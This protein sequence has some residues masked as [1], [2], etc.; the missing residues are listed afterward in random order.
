MKVKGFEIVFEFDE[1]PL[2]FNEKNVKA[3]VHLRVVCGRFGVSKELGIRLIKESRALIEDMS[4]FLCVC[5]NFDDN[6][7]LFGTIISM[8]HEIIEQAYNFFRFI[9]QVAIAQGNGL[10]I[11]LAKFMNDFAQDHGGVEVV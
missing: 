10:S 11:F 5:K 1:L 7:F 6:I 9:K 2:D 8:I 3:V 4:V